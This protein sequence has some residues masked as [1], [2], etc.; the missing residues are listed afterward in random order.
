[1]SFAVAVPTEPVKLT[2]FC[3][4]KHVDT[5]M[6]DLDY[7]GSK[8]VT[9]KYSPADARVAWASS[10]ESVATVADGVITAAG[11]GTATITL[12]VTYGP[13]TRTAAIEVLVQPEG[14]LT[15]PEEF[16]S[17][18]T[19]TTI[20]GTTRYVLDEDGVEESKPYIVYALSGERVMHNNTNKNA[21]DHCRP[22]MD[23]EQMIA[24]HAADS[25]SPTDDLWRLEEQEDGAFAFKSITNGKYLT[26]A[27]SGS[28]LALGDAA[29]PFTV[30]PPTS[31]VSTPP[32]EVGTVFWNQPAASPDRSAWGYWAR[33]A[34]LNSSRGTVTWLR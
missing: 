33:K 17:A 23:G 28:Q 16:K 13:L 32:L 2:F 30:T 6:I 4:A 7:N 25:W 19:S 26:A 21:T 22:T 24:N 5:A 11:A 20:P 12:S 18:L 3:V 14:G 15:L 34:V 8:T 1:M 9:P 27:A 31:T 10:D 29:V